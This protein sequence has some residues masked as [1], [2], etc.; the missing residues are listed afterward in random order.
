MDEAGDEALREAIKR[1]H[2]VDANWVESVPVYAGFKGQAVWDGEVQIYELIGHPKAK[3]CYAWSED[4]GQDFFAVLALPP[5]QGRNARGP[6]GGRSQVE[7]GWIV[8]RKRT[9]KLATAEG[10][11]PGLLINQL[12][13]DLVE[14]IN[15]HDGT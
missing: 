13:G 4:A 8:K 11:D 15:D 5:G 6:R 3:R 10:P 2:G 12:Y 14:D 7:A 1:T 9:V